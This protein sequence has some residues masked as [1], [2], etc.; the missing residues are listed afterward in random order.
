MSE[1]VLTL[2]GFNCQIEQQY[3]AEI[4]KRFP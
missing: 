4:Y 1:F 2:T 3:A